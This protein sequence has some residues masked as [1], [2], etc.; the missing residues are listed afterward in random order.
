LCSFQQKANLIVYVVD[1]SDISK[2]EEASQTLQSLILSQS[3]LNHVP[4]LIVGNKN[5]IEGSLTSEQLMQRL[6]PDGIKVLGDRCLAFACLRLPSLIC[7]LFQPT[8]AVQ[9]VQRQEKA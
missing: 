8:I 5:D 2:M 3:S 7:F 4:L 9:Q 6:F 1:A